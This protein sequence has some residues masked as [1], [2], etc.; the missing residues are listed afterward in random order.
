MKTNFYV[1]DSTNF[2]CNFDFTLQ[3]ALF[4]GKTQLI[5]VWKWSFPRVY[6]SMSGSWVMFLKMTYRFNTLVHYRI[7]VLKKL[8]MAWGVCFRY[9]TAV[10]S[11]VGHGI[12]LHS[13]P[14]AAVPFSTRKTR[15]HRSIRAKRNGLTSLTRLSFSKYIFLKTSFSPG[16]VCFHWK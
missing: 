2:Q 11:W 16:R 6:K 14:L 10:Q 8:V 1:K 3:P 4:I 15:P 9:M 13:P 12:L 7:T 5:I